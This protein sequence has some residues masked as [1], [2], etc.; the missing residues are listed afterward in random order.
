MAARTAARFLLRL[1]TITGA[2]VGVGLNY[3]NGTLKIRI[4]HRFYKLSWAANLY[5]K[6][7]LERLETARRQLGDVVLPPEHV[8]E[9]RVLRI[10]RF[11]RVGDTEEANM[12]HLLDVLDHLRRAGSIQQ[13]RPLD[14]PW[15]TQFEE[16]IFPLD[17]SVGSSMVPLITIVGPIHG[18]LHAQNVLIVGG[19]PVLIDLDLYDPAGL[20]FFDLINIF[21]SRHMIEEGLPW[22]RAVRRC[23][24][25]RDHLG[26]YGPW[27]EMPR[28]DQDR[29]LVLYFIWRS[30]NE[31][32]LTHQVPRREDLDGLVERLGST[33]R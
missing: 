24:E 30:V 21:V 15:F 2:R 25:L 10:A 9:G 28:P 29:L 12:E 1:A 23:V 3:S 22:T 14:A 11:A 17:S 32:T 7:E 26:R 6:G 27:A 20:H 19:R 18:D 16:S 4:S 33:G 31:L 13:V 8:R 5:F